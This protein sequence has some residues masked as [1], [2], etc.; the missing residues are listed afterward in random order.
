M[1]AR[2]HNLLKHMQ[3]LPEAVLIVGAS[4]LPSLAMTGLRHLL[5]LRS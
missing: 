5:G 3:C 2:L 1:R 4:A